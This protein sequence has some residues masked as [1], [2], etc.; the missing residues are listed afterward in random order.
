MK[1]LGTEELIGLVGLL[2]IGVAAFAISGWWGLL[3]FVGGLMIAGALVLASVR[4][5]GRGR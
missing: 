1:L 5:N 2:A 4:S 3:G